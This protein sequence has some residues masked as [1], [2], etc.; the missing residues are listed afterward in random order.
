MQSGWA[1]YN[2]LFKLYK[3]FIYTIYTRILLR[4]NVKK[5]SG[6]IPFAHF[7][8]FITMS[9]QS[10]ARKVHTFTYCTVVHTFKS[11]IT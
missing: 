4:I 9:E 1:T 8:V 11:M 3:Q 2:D 10:P 7:W 5:D 6:S